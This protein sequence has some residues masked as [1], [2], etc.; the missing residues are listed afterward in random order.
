MWGGWW[1]YCHESSFFSDILGLDDL[2]ELGKLYKHI[3]KI[4]YEICRKD[5]DEEDSFK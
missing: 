3:Y 4:H 2:D 1:K 5:P